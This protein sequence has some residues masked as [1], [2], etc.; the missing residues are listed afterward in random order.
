MEFSG[1]PF[2]CLLAENAPYN[3]LTFSQKQL[4]YIKTNH[5]C[6][7]SHH[8]SYNYFTST[9]LSIS[10]FYIFHKLDCIYYWKIHVVTL[11]Q[12]FFY[13]S[14]PTICNKKVYIKLSFYIKRCQDNYLHHKTINK[15]RQQWW[16]Q[17][18]YDWWHTYQ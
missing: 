16:K 5:E 11:L 17:T 10:R 3:N 13:N 2:S 7:T 1:L 9:I 8:I 12:I 6:N 15:P 4:H 18:K 14:S